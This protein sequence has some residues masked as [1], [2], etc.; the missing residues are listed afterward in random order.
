MAQGDG[1]IYNE[2]KEELLLGNI[3]MDGHTF[4]VMLVTG[5]T[6]NI[7]SHNGYADV[8]AQEESGTGYTAGGATPVRELVD[9]HY[10]DVAR[11]TTSGF[12]RAKLGPEHETLIGTV[13]NVGYRFVP[14]R[15]RDTIVAEVDAGV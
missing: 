7:D 3:D 8:S 13:R 6:P 9:R 11:Y 5:Y 2:F 1:A 4:K 15:P 10:V 14:E 12:L